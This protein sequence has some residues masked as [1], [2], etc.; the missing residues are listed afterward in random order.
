MDDSSPGIAIYEGPFLAKLLPMGHG[1]HFD[2]VTF[3]A[4]AGVEYMIQVAS[5][6]ATTGSFALVWDINGAESL[7]TVRFRR[8]AR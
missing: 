1:L 5:K 2:R 4:Q 3:I 6:S 7:E 8:T